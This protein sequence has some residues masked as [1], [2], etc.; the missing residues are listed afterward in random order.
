MI[1]GSLGTCGGLFSL[2]AGASSILKSFTS[3]P[4][5]T[6]YSYIASEAGISS[7]GLP[8]RPSVPNDVTFSSATVEVSELISWRVPTYL[9][10]HQ[11]YHRQIVRKAYRMSL[12]DTRDIL[13]LNAN[14]SVKFSKVS[15]S[16]FDLPYELRHCTV[17]LRSAHSKLKT[18]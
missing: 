1:A 18:V 13:A 2:A 7:S 16:A 17:I 6:M 5:K 12:R 9:A 14:V 3:L 11:H 4:R 10:L 15:C 8:F